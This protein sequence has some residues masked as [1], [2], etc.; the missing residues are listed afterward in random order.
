MQTRLIKIVEDPREVAPVPHAQEPE[1][2]VN[3]TPLGRFTYRRPKWM[4]V[5]GSAL[6]EA[7]TSVFKAV[8]DG[9]VHLEEVP[10]S[11]AVEY[12]DAAGRALTLG[13]IYARH[14]MSETKFI[15]SEQLHTAILNEQRSHIIRYFRSAVAL[16]SLEIEIVSQKNGSLYAGTGWKSAGAS[17]NMTSEQRRWFAATY[18][19]PRKEPVPEGEN[20]FW[21]EHFDEIVSATRDVSGGTIETSSS[22]NMSFGLT[23]EAAKLGKID[24]NWLSQQSFIVRAEYI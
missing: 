11:R 3:D 2:I 17:K 10:V 9:S 14:P 8:R 5:A 6:A 20:L 12:R 7:A 16:K 1:T 24:G 19:D 4:D 18:S 15:V 21:M 13:G 22:I 23:A